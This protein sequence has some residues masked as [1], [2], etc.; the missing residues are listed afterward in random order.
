MA[1]CRHAAGA[2]PDASISISPASG[3][4]ADNLGRQTG[5]GQDPSACICKQ[6][7]SP[8]SVQMVHARNARQAGVRG[9]PGLTRKGPASPTY[10]KDRC[11]AA[12]ATRSGLP[13]QAAGSGDGLA[14]RPQKP[15]LRPD[16]RRGL[17]EIR[18]RGRAGPAVLAARALQTSGGTLGCSLETSTTERGL[19][20]APLL[21]C[22]VKGRP[23]GQKQPACSR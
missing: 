19:C 9:V 17:S 18:G 20:Q 8:T 6:P 1:C 3:T 12:G 4:G 7:C 21:D 14:R 23:A 13:A 22:V 2:S 15:R 11:V 10:A 16:R 5:S